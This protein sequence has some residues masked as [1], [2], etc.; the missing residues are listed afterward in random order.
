MMGK[1]T[2]KLRLPL[3]LPAEELQERIRQTLQKYGLLEKVKN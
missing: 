2:P 3:D 1:I